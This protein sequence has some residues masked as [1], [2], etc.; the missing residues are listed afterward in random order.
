MG[1]IF[2]IDWLPTCFGCAPRAGRLVHQEQVTNW[3]A[4][5]FIRIVYFNKIF[6]A[7]VQYTLVS[8]QKI[9]NTLI[10]LRIFCHVTRKSQVGNFLYAV[11]WVTLRNYFSFLLLLLLTTLC[12][13][14][15]SFCT[16]FSFST[17]SFFFCHLVFASFTYNIVLL[18]VRCQL[19]NFFV[20][21]LFGLSFLAK[22]D[23]LSLTHLVRIHTM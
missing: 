18:P 11:K 10:C 15:A 19:G 4:C 5:S 23:I 2:K 9:I 6:T 22:Q 3:N 12:F 13:S 14:T 20:A 21:V 1:V 17:F 8:P 7:S 16:L